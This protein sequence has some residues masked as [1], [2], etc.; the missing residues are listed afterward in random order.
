MH[1]FKAFE[2]L[3][4]V[5]LNLETYCTIYKLQVHVLKLG[6]HHQC[7]EKGFLATWAINDLDFHKQYSSL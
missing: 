5:L 7:Y 3:M 1:I 2:Y 4:L 6:F